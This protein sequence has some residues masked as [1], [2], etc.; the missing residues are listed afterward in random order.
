MVYLIYVHMFETLLHLV[1]T[2]RVDDQTL[3][4]QH[5]P[6]NHCGSRPSAILTALPLSGLC[7]YRV[8]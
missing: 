7:F 1:L 3:T 8:R 6:K 4:E 2:E 5:V